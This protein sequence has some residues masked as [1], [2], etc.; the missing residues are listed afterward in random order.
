MAKVFSLSADGQTL[1][2]GS[3]PQSHI[4]N[5]TLVAKLN[6]LAGAVPTAQ[7]AHGWT[8]LG[9]YCGGRKQSIAWYKDVQ[10]GG[11]RYRAMYFEAFLPIK[12]SW[13]AATYRPGTFGTVKKA[14]WFRWEPLVWNVLYNDGNQAFASCSIVVDAKPFNNTL[15]LRTVGGK[16]IYPNDY[17]HSSIRQWLNGVFCNEAFS[18]AEQASLASW[19]VDNRAVTTR[20]FERDYESVRDKVSLLSFSEISTPSFG[21]LGDMWDKPPRYCLLGTP[22]AFCNGLP[23]KQSLPTWWYRSAQSKFSDTDTNVSVSG[24]DHICNSE[25]WKPDPQEVDCMDVGV[26]PAICVQLAPSVQPRPTV[27]IVE[28]VVTKQVPVE[29][30]VTKTV[31]KVVTKRVEAAPSAAQLCRQG[32]DAHNNGDYAKAFALFGQASFA[33]DVD[34]MAWLAYCY[35]NGQGTSENRVQACYWNKLAAEQGNVTAQYNLAC[36]YEAGNGVE[37]NIEEAAYW[38]NEAAEHGNKKAQAAYKR[39]EKLLDGD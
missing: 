38:Y 19:F 25:F 27:K 32:V 14:Y 20:N 24:S 6:A 18:A 30:I 11:N 36:A 23:N 5:P 28:K 3:Y 34:A 1:V 29:K 37:K 35:I 22:Y 13:Q 2:I 39:L 21:F 17:A 16:T 10:H 8:D 9:C 33:G 15:A 7:N 4:D 31:E 26:V 12:A